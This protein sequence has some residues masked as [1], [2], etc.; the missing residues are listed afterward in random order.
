LLKPFHLHD[1]FSAFHPG[2]DRYTGRRM[3]QRASSTT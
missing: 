1:V 2:E 3:K